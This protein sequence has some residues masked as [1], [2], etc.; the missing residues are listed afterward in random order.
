MLSVERVMSESRKIDGAQTIG[1][2]STGRKICRITGK[3]TRV[4]G[5]S[6][7]PFTETET[8]RV[9]SRRSKGEGCS[10]T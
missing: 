1:L 8:E 7:G 6:V 4:N 2:F 9:Q 3:T 5:L 10:E